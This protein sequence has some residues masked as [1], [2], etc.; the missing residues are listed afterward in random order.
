VIAATGFICARPELAPQIARWAD[1]FSPPQA[2]SHEDLLRHLY[3]GPHFELTERAQDAAPQLKYLYNY[4]FEGRLSLG[5][6]QSLCARILS[7]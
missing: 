5:F 2:E 6:G 4:T 1:R 7:L 3:L